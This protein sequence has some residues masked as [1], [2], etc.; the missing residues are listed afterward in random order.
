MLPVLV[1]TGHRPWRPPGVRQ[2]S[3]PVPPGLRRWQP[4]LDM[5]VLDAA[6][7]SADDGNI[8][9]AA[10]LLRLQRCRQPAG[11]AAALFDA[12]RRD[13]RPAELLEQLSDAL[14][15]ML[16]ARFGDDET[17]E[18]YTEE[19]RGALRHMEEP[20]MLAETVTRWRQE[21]LAEGE[22]M[23]LRRQAARRFGV[24]T[25]DALAALLAKEEDAE[26]LAEVGELLVDCGSSAELLRR[27]GGLLN[28]RD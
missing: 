10:A 24:E 15:R 4:D 5:L 20:K 2:L 9:P 17:V 19:L 26:R 8:N 22:R 14:M 21:A 7:L 28:G 27:G 16:A 18:G 23:L 13:R 25:G 12:L 6:T 11:L 3:A 1:Y